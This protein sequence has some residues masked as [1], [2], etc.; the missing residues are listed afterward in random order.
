[1]AR[2]HP[3]ELSEKTPSASGLLQENHSEPQNAE[4]L[5]DTS[6]AAA[7][8]RTAPGSTERRAYPMKYGIRNSSAIG[9]DSGRERNN[10]TIPSTQCSLHGRHDD[11]SQDYLVGVTNKLGGDIRP[12]VSSPASRTGKPSSPPAPG[13]CEIID[14]GTPVGDGSLVMLASDF[15]KREA[16]AIP[17]WRCS[18]RASPRTKH[19]TDRSKS[20]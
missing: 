14:F 6:P 20:Y 10:E 1:M 5:S 15:P 11:R 8:R 19:S 2:D 3:F 18:A 9:A 4:Q 16:R 7:V 13:A 12:P 17:E